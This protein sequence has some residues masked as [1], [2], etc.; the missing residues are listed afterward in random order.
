MESPL[1]SVAALTLSPRRG[2]V[3]HELNKRV[4]RTL[5]S[6]LLVAS[7]SLGC[8]VEK[9]ATA[10][11][12]MT[13]CP[14]SDVAK[15]PDVVTAAQPVVET[16]P[17]FELEPDFRRLT[18]DDFDKFGAEPDTWGAS[19]EGFSC[20]GKPRGYLYSL[21]AYQDFTWRFDYRFPRPAKLTDDSKFKGNTGFLVYITGP[22]KLWPIC[23]EVQGK[24]A[25]IATVKEN[26]GAQPVSVED[27]NEARQRSRAPVGQWNA[28]EVVSRS[29]ELRV[30]LNGSL[31]SHS[32]P[33][34][35]S[36][37]LIGVQ[38]EDH[39]FEVRRMRIRRD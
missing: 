32:K 20:T 17:E 24:H 14:P 30:F 6:S 9:P 13:D 1:D 16:Q 33:D 12:T 23:L 39:P 18:L 37:G 22:H 31:I 2:Q 21:D 27:D 10:P 29:G 28:I 26:G 8:R 35:L 5:F 3:L 25:Q 4:L 19:E 11:V 38:A 36:E 7:L 34:F 15:S